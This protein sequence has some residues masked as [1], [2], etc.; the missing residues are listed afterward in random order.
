MNYK[1]SLFAE[2]TYPSPVLILEISIV[3]KL[4]LDC[5]ALASRAPQVSAHNGVS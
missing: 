3:V 1:T 5:S 4:G 2:H